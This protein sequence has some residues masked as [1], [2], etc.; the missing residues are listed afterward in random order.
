MAAN[1][2]IQVRVV[3]TRKGDKKRGTPLV[4]VSCNS[5]YRKGTLPSVVSE[6]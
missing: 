4:S 3:A 1:A 5:A 2:T 6:H